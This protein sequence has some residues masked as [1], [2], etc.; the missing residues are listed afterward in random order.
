M[1]FKHLISVLL[2]IGLQTGCLF[3][4]TKEAPTIQQMEESLDS[5]DAEEESSSVAITPESTE[6][7][8]EEFNEPKEDFEEDYSGYDE[9]DPA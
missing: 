6:E 8:T 2:I 4:K 3:G 7:L 5:L 1:T 9:D